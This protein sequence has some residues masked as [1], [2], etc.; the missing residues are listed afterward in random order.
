MATV[1]EGA[2]EARETVG[3]R[4]CRVE[5]ERARPNVVFFFCRV[6]LTPLAC[7]SPSGAGSFTNF[8]LCLRV[9]RRRPFSVGAVVLIFRGSRAAERGENERLGSGGGGG[10]QGGGEGEGER[11]SSFERRLRADSWTYFC[12]SLGGGLGGGG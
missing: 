9:V 11:G 2:C 7:T 12:S 3:E 8:G 10:G 5:V 6:P 4:V 1:S